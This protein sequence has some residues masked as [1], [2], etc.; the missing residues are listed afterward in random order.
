MKPKILI[1]LTI[2]LI[3]SCGSS[4]NNEAENTNSND[5]LQTDLQ[6]DEASIKMISDKNKS[7]PFYII[8]ISATKDIEEACEQVLDLQK[9]YDEVGYLWI[10]DYESLSGKEMYA[11]FLGPYNSK[12]KCI[13]QLAEYQKENENV[14]AVVADHK[15][16]RIEIRGKYD[17]KIDGKKQEPEYTA[18]IAYNNPSRT[19]DFVQLCQDNFNCYIQIDDTKDLTKVEIID[20]YSKELITTV[21]IS[22]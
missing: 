20:Y 18:I 10:P 5:T 13:E 16:E 19:P 8:N 21:D 11:V 4:K 3:F 12:T 7:T 14:Y 22:G 17:I 2:F 1:L 9:K 6:D 15:K